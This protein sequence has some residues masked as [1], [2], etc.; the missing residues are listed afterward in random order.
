MNF[1]GVIVNY[2]L[3]Q[4]KP[5]LVVDGWK[6]LFELGNWCHLYSCWIPDHITIIDNKNAG[7]I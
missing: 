7:K 1:F 3:I 6:F 4:L 2:W 5:Y